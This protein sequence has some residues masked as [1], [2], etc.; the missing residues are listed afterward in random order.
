MDQL[1][2]C[3]RLIDGNGK[4]SLPA[5]PRKVE[6]TVLLLSADQGRNSLKAIRLLLDDPYLLSPAATVVRS[7]YEN[8]VRVLWATLAPDG[9]RR[10]EKGWAEQLLKF[11]KVS[12]IAK[13]ESKLRYRDIARSKQRVDRF[14]NVN[15]PPNAWQMLTQIYNRLAKDGVD[16]TDVTC[17]AAFQYAFLYVY[18]SMHTHSQPSAM[19]P[20]SNLV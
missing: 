19:A 20:P 1:Q 17:T 12:A 9:W 10:L 3:Y 18:P 2:E 8:S 13:P 16:V 11:N 15:R 4:R 5:H 6:G 7:F 14:R